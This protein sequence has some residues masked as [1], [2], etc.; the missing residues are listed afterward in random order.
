MSHIIANI[1]FPFLFQFLIM[2]EKQQLHLTK[3]SLGI[4]ELISSIA[5][6]DLIRWIMLILVKR[7]ESL[8]NK[9]L[10]KKTIY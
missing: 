10:S 4:K 1:F 2:T 6:K 3:N 7:E 8:Q 9:L 5:S